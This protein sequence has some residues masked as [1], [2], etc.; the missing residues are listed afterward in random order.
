MEETMNRPSVFISSTIAD[1]RDLRSALK[2]WFEKKGFRV[3]LSEYNNFGPIGDA[4][5]V[6]AC[7]CN[8]EKSDYFI[9]LVGERAGTLIED[10][11][12]TRHEYRKAMELSK[13]KGLK[14][15]RFVRD[16][17]RPKNGRIP[18]QT[19]SDPHQDAFVQELMGNSDNGQKSWVYYFRTFDDVVAALVKELGNEEDI[20]YIRLLFYL[21]EELRENLGLILNKLGD[22]IYVGQFWPCK[23]RANMPDDEFGD[24]SMK[25]EDYEVLYYFLL[26]GPGIGLRLNTRW[27]T[28]SLK[29]GVFLQWCQKTNSFTTNHK[30]DALALIDKTATKCRQ[31]SDAL[32]T[33][34]YLRFRVTMGEAHKSKTSFKFSKG[35]LTIPMVLLDNLH[36]M[37]E[38][39]RYLYRKMNGKPDD[40]NKIP[41][42]RVNNPFSKQ[43][44]NINNETLSREEIDSYIL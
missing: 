16:E 11:S 22:K 27:I 32:K 40:Y 10:I 12:V 44:D 42:Y 30:H 7:L 8:I 1:M 41:L 6:E 3:Y 4:D 23:L 28:E 13:N 25:Y 26:F 24:I 35:M 20:E 38:L 33:D 9:V 34:P 39:T 36:N 18:S 21:S 29:K 2:W 19:E 5:P 31:L 43:N 14:I 15:V 17:I 37:F